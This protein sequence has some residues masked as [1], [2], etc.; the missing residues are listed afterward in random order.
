MG[1][2]SPCETCDDIVSSRIRAARPSK[3]RLIPIYNNGACTN[4]RGEGEGASA[5]LNA[6]A[7]QS[8]T[9]LRDALRSRS[10]KATLVPIS[11]EDH[12]FDFDAKSPMGRLVMGLHDVDSL[13][14]FMELDEIVH[15][16]LNMDSPTPSMFR[17][18]FSYQRRRS[19]VDSSM[20]SMTQVLDDWDPEPED[21]YDHPHGHGVCQV[22]ADGDRESLDGAL[23]VDDDS[24]S[25]GD[26]DGDDD[27][28]FP[29]YTPLDL[30]RRISRDDELDM[31]HELR[32]LTRRHSES[33]SR[34]EL[35]AVNLIDTV[36][37]SD[38]GSSSGSDSRSES[39]ESTISALSAGSTAEGDHSSDSV[40]ES[41]E[42]GHL[43]R[44]HS[45]EKW[46][47]DSLETQTQEMQRQISRLCSQ[48]LAF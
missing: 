16:E 1:N 27:E 38:S 12:A 46:D 17:Q 36:T 22:L 26:S 28:Y 19:S 45:A 41:V 32:M 6:A 10:S 39:A 2:T 42:R 5:R 43:L 24:D 44:E 40:S 30:V 47:D 3:P 11:Y 48:H 15:N 20:T 34:R 23:S 18:S 4:P 33:L 25:D 21:I 35:D 14:G 31:R 8:M 9:D 7:R 29:E 37:D 13:T